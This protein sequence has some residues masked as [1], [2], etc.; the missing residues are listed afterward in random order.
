[1]EG[2]K[3]IADR[4]RDVLICNLYKAESIVGP[5]SVTNIF[6]WPCIFFICLV[7]SFNQFERG[8]VLAFL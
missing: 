7:Y 8:S 6:I 2:V 4:K 3:L 5:S 1:M